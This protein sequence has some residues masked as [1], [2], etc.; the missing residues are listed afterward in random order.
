MRWL[1]VGLCFCTAGCFDLTVPP[2]TDDKPGTVTATV[3]SQRPGRADLIP[4]VGAR[5]ELVGSSRVAKA[6]DD[7]TVRL[8]GLTATTGTLRLA[9]DADGDGTDDASRVFDLAETGAGFGKTSNL[10]V[11]VLGRLSTVAGK[12]RRGDRDAS[13]GQGGIQVFLPGSPASTVSADDGSFVLAGLPQGSLPISFFAPGYAPASSR[14]G[15]GA[16]QEQRLADVSLKVDANLTSGSVT[17]TVRSGTGGALDGVTVEVTTA[18][19]TSLTMADAQG[20]FTVM[21]VAPGLITLTFHR[22]GYV[23]IRVSN[24]LVAP[25]QA[26]TQPIVLE[27]GTGEL[28]ALPGAG[29]GGSGITAGPVQ[30]ISQSVTDAYANDGGFDVLPPDLVQAGDLVVLMLLRQDTITPLPNG[31]NGWRVLT[32]ELILNNDVAEILTRTADAQERTRPERYRF[33]TPA[34]VESVVVV[35]RHADRV[36]LVSA[37][38]DISPLSFA[39]IPAAP[40]DLTADAFVANDVGRRCDVNRINPRLAQLGR[41]TF[42]PWAGAAPD[43]T[44]TCDLTR[45]LAGI[46][47]RLRVLAAP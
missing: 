12:V 26:V 6:N 33:Q 35:L 16:G 11:V 38:D 18:G 17:G 20:Q 30:L 2:R 21:N 41:W 27:A 28:P 7:G 42:S 14:V 19:M 13:A 8:E 40:G 32:S 44:M 29:D 31:V 37:F 22:D 46:S 10:G 9:Y 45:G 5:L 39:G 25:G 15:L 43:T 1:T 36:A 4:A 34:F 24:V 3:L 23:P 47:Y